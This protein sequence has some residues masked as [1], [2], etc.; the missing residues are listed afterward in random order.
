MLYYTTRAFPTASRQYEAGDAIDP[1]SV[2]AAEWIKGTE[3]GAVVPARWYGTAAV[4][5]AR[6]IPGPGV[7]VYETDTRVAR[8]GDG[9]TSVAS[10]PQVGSSTYGAVALA[11]RSGVYIPS[12]TAA[13]CWHQTRSKVLS[14]QTQ[15]NITWLGDSIGYG[16]ATTGATQP[17]A[18]KTAAGLLRTSLSRRYGAS[19]GGFALCDNIR[20]FGSIGDD[21]RFAKTAG[22]ITQAFGLHTASCWRINQGTADTIS[23]TDTCSE[24]LLYTIAGGNQFEVTVDG[25]ATINLHNTASATFTG[26][27]TPEAGY[28]RNPATNSHNVFKIPAGAAGSHT[29]LIRAKASGNVF[30]VGIEGRTPTA[31]TFRVGN[32]SINGKA[33]STFWAYTNEDSGIYSGPLFLDMLKSDL[34]VLGLGV[35]DWQSA[36]ATATTK[37]T[38]AAIVARQRATTTNAYGSVASGG[39]VV[40]VWNPIPDTATLNYPNPSWSDYRTAMYEAADANDVALIDLG[41]AWGG[42]WATANAAGLYSDTIHP[43]DAGYLDYADRVRRVIMETI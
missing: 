16:A 30:V 38:I 19:G 22:V 5:A 12:P 14:G 35:N 26:D 28:F 17:K 20:L 39:D 15:A 24:F 34:L 7:P 29:L 1:A 3:S 6:G 42:T 9:I 31:G 23:F 41:D 18:G 10:L 43:T 8:V 4:L 33:L 13:R 21:T 11:K 37:A 27:I 32:A 36:T 25:G 2:T 40:L